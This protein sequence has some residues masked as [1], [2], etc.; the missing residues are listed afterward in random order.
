MDNPLRLR[1]SSSSSV[2]ASVRRLFFPLSLALLMVELEQEAF[3]RP[4]QLT[5]VEMGEFVLALV[6]AGS[7]FVLGSTGSSNDRTALAMVDTTLSSL[8][9]RLISG[10]LRLSPDGNPSLKR[11]V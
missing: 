7:L 1:S 8:G 2:V 10:V 5:R 6:D 9:S 3:I 4:E 11:G